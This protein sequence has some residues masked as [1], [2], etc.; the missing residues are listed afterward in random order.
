MTPPN[1][2]EV[3]ALKALIRR[4]GLE[5]TKKGKNWLCR[6]PFHED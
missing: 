1:R 5:P 6:C 4:S 2:E 3:D